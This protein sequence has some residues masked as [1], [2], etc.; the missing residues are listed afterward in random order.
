[1]GQ[2]TDL[3]IEVIKMVPSELTIGEGGYAEIVFSNKGSDIVER[4]VRF[5]VSVSDQ[6]DMGEMNLLDDYGIWKVINKQVKPGSVTMVMVNE[7][8]VV[9]SGAQ[10]RMLFKFKAIRPICFDCGV[11]VGNVSLT[12]DAKKVYENDP[13]NNG[14]AGHF[15][16]YDPQSVDV[17]NLGVTVQGCKGVDISWSSG[18]E[19][20]DR[21]V[22]VEKSYDGEIFTV[23]RSVRPQGMQ[24]DARKQVVVRDESELRR[25]KVYYRLRTVNKEGMLGFSRTVSSEVSCDEALGMEIYPNPAYNHTT[26]RLTGFK[27]GEPVEC[28]LTNAIGDVVRKFKI[29]PTGKTTVDLENLPGGAYYLQVQDSNNTSLQSRFIKVD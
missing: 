12:I 28:S 16:V 21:T 22:E 2:N 15:T 24:D 25:G 4:G 10:Y 14:L 1:M 7:G 29:D 3:K 27:A 19:V 11:I 13:Y 8:G 5:N 18:P 23:V 26:V 9:K 17:G 20:E 6:L